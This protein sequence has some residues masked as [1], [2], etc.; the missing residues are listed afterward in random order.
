MQTE[1]YLAIANTVLDRVLG[2]ADGPPTERRRKL[3]GEPPA[4]GKEREAAGNVARTLAR[5]AFRRPASEQEIETLLKVFDLARA[6]KLS[7]MASLRLML[8][9]VLVSPQFLFVTPAKSPEAG[10]TIVP[11]DDHH[12]ASRL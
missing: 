2:P 8:K 12:L 10:R 1:Q 5:K 11:L 3:L 7:Y 9:A 6:N 4:H